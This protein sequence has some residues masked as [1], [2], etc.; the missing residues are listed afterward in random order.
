[1]SPC[2]SNISGVQGGVLMLLLR[3]GFEHGLGDVRYIYT[4]LLLNSTEREGYTMNKLTALYT[5]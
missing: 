5:H 1:M 3:F 2:L 4:R